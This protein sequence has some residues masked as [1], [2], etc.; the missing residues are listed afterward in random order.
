MAEDSRTWA[1]TLVDHAR[2]AARAL[3]PIRDDAPTLGLGARRLRPFLAIVHMRIGG[4]VVL[5]IGH[6]LLDHVLERFELLRCHIFG[7]ICRLG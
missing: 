1:S 5:G 4:M 7:A 2:P 3:E 6:G